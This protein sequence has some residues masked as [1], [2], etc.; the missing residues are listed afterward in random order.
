TNYF[1][2]VQVQSTYIPLYLVQGNATVSKLQVKSITGNG[3][4]HTDTYTVVKNGVDTTMVVAIT[5]GTTGS[6]TANPVSLVA[7]DTIGIKV[8]ADA[9]TTVADIYALMIV[10]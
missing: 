4:A 5:N 6:T 10:Q 1:T 2:P 9:A 3:A 7:G 8:V